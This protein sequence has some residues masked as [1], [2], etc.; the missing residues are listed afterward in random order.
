[1]MN[2]I[3]TMFSNIQPFGKRDTV[4]IMDV[5]VGPGFHAIVGD[6]NS[7]KTFFAQKYLRDQYGFAYLGVDEPDEH[8]LSLDDNY[9]LG[10]ILSS[11][12][13]QPY[14]VVAGIIDSRRRALFNRLVGL[15]YN[16]TAIS[17][18]LEVD[19]QVVA[20]T[21]SNLPVSVARVPMINTLVVN[22][23][24]GRMYIPD[25]DIKEGL[26]EGGVRTHLFL[27]LT[28]LSIFCNTLGLIVFG[29]F[30]APPKGLDYFASRI[31]QSCTSIWQAPHKGGL[32]V[33][34]RQ[35]NER[36]KISISI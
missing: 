7:G 8:L 34:S 6:E 5:A 25:V 32:I 2:S 9:F 13:V 4:S 26:T 19:V 22:S 16:D 15:G 10:L 33:K 11:L 30:P 14:N 36:E 29:V 23:F 35:F 28:A 27:G 1:M 24:K 20:R 31:S 12:G 17:T 3:F 18:I 21:R